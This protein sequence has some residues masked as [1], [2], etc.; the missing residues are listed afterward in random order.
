[1]SQYVPDAT[2]KKIELTLREYIDA[3][4]L[5][6]SGEEAA[7]LHFVNMMCG[8]MWYTD[9]NKLMVRHNDIAHAMASLVPPA[10]RAYRMRYQ[11]RISRP[12]RH[13]RT[14][15]PWRRRK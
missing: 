13:P 7:I 11:R 14:M 10:T 2:K 9:D 8:D 6:V 4:G 12:R 1:M 5:H 15:P 3:T